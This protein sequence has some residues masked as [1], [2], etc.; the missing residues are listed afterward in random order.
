MIEERGSRQMGNQA[1]RVPD[2][3]VDRWLAKIHRQQLPVEVGKMDQRHVA[4]WLEM[5][6]IRLREPLPG[7]TARPTGREDGGGCGGELDK[8]AS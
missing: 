8:L 6:K 7:E 1:A 4:E 3:E 2:A 5:Q